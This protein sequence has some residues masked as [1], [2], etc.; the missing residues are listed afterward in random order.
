[1]AGRESRIIQHLRRSWRSAGA[2][3][4]V[5]LGYSGGADSL[6]LLVLL[7]EL[8]RLEPVSLLALHVDHA[9][10]SESA[11]EAE[12]VRLNAVS[13][14]VPIIV[15]RLAEHV[16]DRH[17]GVGL[18]EAMRRERYAALARVARE[19]HAIIAVAH[20]ERD[21]AE[22]LLLHLMRGAGL[23]GVA[24]MREMTHLVVPWWETGAGAEVTI[25]RPLL[26]VPGDEVRAVAHGTGLAV[27]EDPSNRDEGL[28]RNAIRH[29]VLPVLESVSPGVEQALARFAELAAIDADE[30]EWQATEALVTVR[31]GDDL[32]RDAVLGL[33]PA[34]RNR[35]L[36]M[37][38]VAGLPT[39]CEVSANRIE[40]LVDVAERPG[41][42]RLVQIASGWAVKVTRERL[43]LVHG[44]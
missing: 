40:A 27:V 7:Q 10:R 35:V 44:E 23:A 4:S 38:L 5:V 24:G 11:D 12:M 39:G 30:L 31:S 33:R 16:L 2:P 3:S 32:A 19:R 22:T 6:A 25:W 34:I 42:V 1:M 8:V 21:Q 13:L 29:R 26:T 15:E 17:V 43:R 14:G 20:H 18:E 37:W 9:M 36:R 41:P 28:R